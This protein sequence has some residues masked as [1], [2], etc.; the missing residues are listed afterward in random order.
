MGE[1]NGKTG[2]ANI[3]FLYNVQ[4]IGIDYKKIVEQ[5][6]ETKWSFSNLKAMRMRAKSSHLTLKT[7]KED[8]GNL[9]AM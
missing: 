3:L 2:G 4:L 5:E 7:G 9:R 6:I 1:A 8:G